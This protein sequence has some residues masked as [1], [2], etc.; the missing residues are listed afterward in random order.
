MS[1]LSQFFQVLDEQITVGFTGKIN[2]LRAESRQF[3]GSLILKDGILINVQYLS[4][5]GEHAFNQLIV[6]LH[7]GVELDSICEPEVVI[8]PEINIFQ[9]I[10]E[11]KNQARIELE[12]FLKINH[13]RPPDSVSILPRVEV[14]S[15]G[16]EV[17]DS[18]FVLLCTLA[19]WSKVS[20]IYMNC[21]LPAYKITMDL[22]G[23]RRK[24]AL[25]VLNATNA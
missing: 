22:V 13:L 2:I 8:S 14:L 9:G 19:E 17:T 20:D 15:S 16:H 1:Q 11:L 23:L 5:V 21:P 4:F 24:Q 25:K 3:K 18:E 6:D 10:T 12:R 7:C